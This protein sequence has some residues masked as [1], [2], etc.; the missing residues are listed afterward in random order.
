MKPLISVLIPVYNVERYIRKCLESLFNNKYSEKCEFIIT[1]DC[2]T[3]NSITIAKEVCTNYKNLKDNIKFLKHNENRGLAAARNTG[4]EHATG[5]YILNVDSDDYVE[6]NYLDILYSEAEKSDFD[7]ITCDYYLNSNSDEFVIKQNIEFIDNVS[8]L[9]KLISSQYKAYLWCKLLKRDLFLKNDIRW[10][11]GINLWEDFTICIQ[12]FSHC[13]SFKYINKPLY[14]YVQNPLS[15]V[16][17]KESIKKVSNLI[18]AI[19]FADKYLQ[20]TICDTIYDSI[21]KKIILEKKIATKNAFI[22]ESNYSIQ[23]KYYNIWPEIYELV[24][25]CNLGQFTKFVIKKSTKRSLLNF[26][27]IRINYHLVKIKKIIKNKD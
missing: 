11:E 10:I 14:H 15:Y 25:S 13:K 2:S 23:Q 3:D 17:Q 12:F 22:L 7:C 21:L 6:N 20:N 27:L 9:S 1:D 26:F 5:K 19:N 8:F 16:H 18:D 24:D 4:L